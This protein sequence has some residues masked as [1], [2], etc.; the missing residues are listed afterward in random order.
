VV[1]SPD[2]LD[3][4]V[5]SF[6]GLAD[7]EFEA[8]SPHDLKY[9]CVAFTAGDAENW[10]WPRGPCYW[11]KD[12]PREETIRSFEEAFKTLGFRSCDGDHA[13]PGFDKVAI[14]AKGLT[15][16]HMA[17]QVSEGGWLSK[18]GQSLD[19][20]HAELSGLEGSGY[21]QVCLILKRELNTV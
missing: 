8:R 10:W 13:E 18:M 9:N 6:P 2:E 12:V 17:R 7:S 5:K 19:I 20:W 21:G 1:S 16:R 3:R 14:Y 15:P 4:L 11:P